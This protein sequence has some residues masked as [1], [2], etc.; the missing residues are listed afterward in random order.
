MVL[1]W[2]VAA[3]VAASILASFCAV[4]SKVPLASAIL[5]LGLEVADG[6]RVTRFFSFAYFRSVLAALKGRV[7]AILFVVLLL[8]PALSITFNC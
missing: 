7:Y 3:M 4:R 5:K 1:Y 6:P 2:G 8:P